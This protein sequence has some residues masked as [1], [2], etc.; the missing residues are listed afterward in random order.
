MQVTGYCTPDR[1]GGTIYQRAHCTAQ[2]LIANSNRSL[3]PV[4]LSIKVTGK[5]SFI[6]SSVSSQ[7][8]STC[9]NASD[10]SN[11]FVTPPRIQNSNEYTKRKQLQSKDKQYCNAVEVCRKR[12]KSSA[13]K[14]TI[15]R[16]STYCMI[17]TGHP[18]KQSDA[19]ILKRVTDEYNINL[20]T[21]IASMMAREERISMS[22]ES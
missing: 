13:M 20:T 12:N 16:T 7:L 1:K 3:T 14:I 9:L 18:E 22:P 15:T 2:S 6:Y 10:P 17:P 4:P 8:S 11:T 19:S 5:Y 21:K